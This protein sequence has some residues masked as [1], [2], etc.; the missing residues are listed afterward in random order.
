MELRL[1]CFMFQLL[2]FRTPVSH[3]NPLHGFCLLLEC[4]CIGLQD[5][6]NKK[7][8][9]RFWNLLCFWLTYT[10]LM[11]QDTL[12]ETVRTSPS[13]LVPLPPPRDSLLSTPK[14]SATCLAIWMVWAR[15]KWSLSSILLCAPSPELV[16]PLHHLVSWSMISIILC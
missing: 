4:T 6:P 11:Q 12:E 14:L 2:I 3:V 10:N 5:F 16:D 13:Q 8:Q 1:F 15:P 7:F 9:L